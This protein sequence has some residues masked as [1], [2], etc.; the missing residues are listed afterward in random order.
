[1]GAGTVVAAISTPL[2]RAAPAA[3]DARKP[4]QEPPSAR[5]VDLTPGHPSTRGL[6]DASWRSAW[7]YAAAQDPPPEAPDARGIAALRVAVAQ[8]LL[9]FRGVDADAQ[10]LIVTAGTSDAILLFCLTFRRIHGD[11]RIAVEDPGYPRIRQIVEGLGGAAIPVPV[12]ESGT[13]D[14]SLLEG[15]IPA[16]HALIVTPSHQYPLG[17]RMPLA[18]RTELLAW[19]RRTGTFIIEDDYDSE[20]RYGQMPLPA[21]VSLDVDQSVML[22]GSFS[23]VLTPALRCGYVLAPGAFGDE[24][25]RTREIVEPNVSTVQQAALARYMQS[26]ALSRHIA[27][28]RRDYTHRRTALLATLSA[29]PGLAVTGTEGGLHAV[30]YCR[31][32]ASRVQEDLA[33]R[34]IRVALLSDYRAKRNAA[35]PNAVVLG[36]ARATSL[37]FER[38]LTLFAEVFSK[39]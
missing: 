9:R 14:T 3:P 35:M 25:R 17:G 27:R 15:V 1:M 12:R 21:L 37:E 2:L 31:R 10:D 24:L 11:I 20:F 34:G 36:Y 13:V 30:V 28:V 7:R 19:A 32:D 22:S 4:E 39:V 5:T 33:K 16:P 6:A 26:G 18:D 23:K 38:A 29:I 8:H